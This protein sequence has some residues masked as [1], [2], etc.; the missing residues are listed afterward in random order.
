MRYIIGMVGF[1]PVS[2]IFSHRRMKN[3]SYHIK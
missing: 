1:A 3:K 2:F